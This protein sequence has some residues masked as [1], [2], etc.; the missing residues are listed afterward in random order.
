MDEI[1]KKLELRCY[2]SIDTINKMYP[3]QKYKFSIEKDEYG[4]YSVL[5]RDKLDRI[6]YTKMCFRVRELNNFLSGILFVLE[7]M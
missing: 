6:V 3:K 2:Q 5:C 4:N 1:A 7:D